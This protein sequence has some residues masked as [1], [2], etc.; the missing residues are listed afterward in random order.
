LTSGVP[1]LK[2]DLLTSE[3]QFVSGE[4]TTDSRVMREWNILSCDLVDESGFS[5][6]GVSD[7]DDFETGTHPPRILAKW[8]RMI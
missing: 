3:G 1:Q 8:I 7:E 2:S 5:D 4:L 6:V